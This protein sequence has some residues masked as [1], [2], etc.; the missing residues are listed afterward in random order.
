MQI[1]DLLY[2]KTTPG[3]TFPPDP[4]DPNFFLDLKSHLD[5]NLDYRKQRIKWRKTKPATWDMWRIKEEFFQEFCEK[6]LPVFHRDIEIF[7]NFY[8]DLPAEEIAKLFCAKW[9]GYE[10]TYGIEFVERAIRRCQNGNR[11]NQPNPL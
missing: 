8:P 3:I 1:S 2:H 7:V 9:K 6:D 10:K 5:D 4:G 11:C